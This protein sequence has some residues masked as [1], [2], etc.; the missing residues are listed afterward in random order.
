MASDPSELARK[1]W[2]DAF[3]GAWLQDGRWVISFAR[4]AVAHGAELR[5]RCGAELRVELAQRPERDLQAIFDRVAAER[6][7]IKAAGIVLVGA[8]VDSRRNAVSLDIAA[9]DPAEAHA[10]LFRRYGEAIHVDLLG[11]RPVI[12][13]LT[14]VYDWNEGPHERAL[15]ISYEAG[16]GA[17]YLRTETD[18]RGDAV[19]VGVVVELG[20]VVAAFSSIARTRVDL[21]SPLGSRAV[22]DA[23]NGAR[24]ARRRPA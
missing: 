22:L 5:R 2:P 18:E 4:D 16:G 17:R 20:H 10:W 11:R 19:T 15:E 9:D 7:E 14:R 23:T 6:E 3:A 21:E 12:E 1:L 8:F 24:V 13:T